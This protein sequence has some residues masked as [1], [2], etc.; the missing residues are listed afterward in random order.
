M[1]LM[2]LSSKGGSPACRRRQGAAVSPHPHITMHPPAAAGRACWD[3]H[4]RQGWVRRRSGR[5]PCRGP[6]RAR[7]PGPCPARR[8][9]RRWGGRALEWKPQA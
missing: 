6:A 4:Q 3:C 7:G 2:Q 5:R 8:R 1:W 9:R